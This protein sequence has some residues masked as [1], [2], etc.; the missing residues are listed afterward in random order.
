MVCYYYSKAQDLGLLSVLLCVFFT[1][2]KN[3]HISLFGGCKLPLKQK[4]KK[5]EMSESPI[6][7]LLSIVSFFC[8]IIQGFVFTIYVTSG[9][10]SLASEGNI[11]LYMTNTRNHSATTE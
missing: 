11:K 8:S 10:P 9:K 2:C 6:F 7:S 1:Q 4:K 3:V 5:R